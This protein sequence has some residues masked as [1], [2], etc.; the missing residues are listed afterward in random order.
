MGCKT[1]PQQVTE[2]Q[3]TTTLDSGDYFG[4]SRSGTMYSITFSDFTTQL[5]VTGTLTDGSAGTATPVLRSVTTNDYIL[6]GISGDSG[7]T[8]QLDGNDDILISL[9]LANEGSSSNGAGTLIESSSNPKTF[10]RIRGGS[11]IAV[12]EETGTITITASSEATSTKTVV[13]NDIDDFPAAEAGVI[14]LEADTDYLITADITTSNRFVLPSNDVCVIRA[15]DRRITT[16]TYSGS[17]SMFTYTNPQASIKNIALSA[18]NGTLFASSSSTTGAF[19]LFK[20]FIACDTV[21]SMD[22]LS[23]FT[24]DGV[25][26]TSITTNGLTFT[27]TDIACR[28]QSVLFSNVSAG[29]CYD[30]GT[31]T[32]RRFSIE[33]ATVLASSA[34]TTLLSG[35]AASGNIGSGVLAQVTNVNI[36]GSMTPLNTITI[37]DAQWKFFNSNVI[38]DTRTDAIGYLSASATTTISASGTPVVLNAGGNFVDVEASQM[39]ITTGGRVTY[40]GVQ[41]AKLPINATLSMAPSSGGSQQLGAYI[42]KNGVVITGSETYLTTSSGAPSSISVIWQDTPDNSDY[43]EVFIENDGATNDIVVDKFVF[44]FN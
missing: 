39:T 5:G 26:F 17:D 24:L 1:F 16:L 25:V 19:D 33:G 9:N 3:K 37:D 44:R 6:R 14:T 38:P 28:L 22:N 27:G 4:V 20:V 31:A 7:I 32:F 18:A 11:G 8:A 43:Y 42:A 15:A 36:T 12:S 41:G 35:L 40:D 34:G 10:R 13:V 30:L 29:T 23:T 2:S 21:G